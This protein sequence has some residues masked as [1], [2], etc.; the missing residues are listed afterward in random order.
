M[1]A[2]IFMARS[3]WAPSQVQSSSPLAHLKGVSESFCGCFPLAFWEGTGHSDDRG[4]DFVEDEGVEGDVVGVE[5]W[6]A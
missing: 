2:T 1:P 3:G 5:V 6:L 4:Y